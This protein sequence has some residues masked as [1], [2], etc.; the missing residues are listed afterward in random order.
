MNKLILN[1]GNGI[2]FPKRGEYV[3][4]NLTIYD[5]KKTILFDTKKIGPIDVLYGQ[6]KHITEFEELIN[7]MSLFEKCS[8]E[9]SG[10]RDNDLIG[11]LAAGG[12]IVAEVEILDISNSPHQK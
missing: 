12:N 5:N 1:P 7:E 6:D 3:K 8:F 4:I 11:K 10:T 9:L 2:T